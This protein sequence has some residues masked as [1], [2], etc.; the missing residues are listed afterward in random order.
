MYV[1]SPTPPG[2]NLRAQIERRETVDDRHLEESLQNCSKYIKV[3][4]EWSRAVIDKYPT[5]SHWTLSMCVSSGLVVKQNQDP[6]IYNC[7]RTIVTSRVC[8][9]ASHSCALCG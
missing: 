2:T 3:C 8:H 6:Q 5:P 1:K 4:I 9:Q 7:R